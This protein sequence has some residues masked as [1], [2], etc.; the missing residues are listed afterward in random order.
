MPK[1]DRPEGVALPAHLARV[2]WPYCPMCGKKLDRPS[3]SGI[4]QGCALPE[5]DGCGAAFKII[6]VEVEDESE[7]SE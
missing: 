7:S 2:L 5:N 3:K 1:V 6:P 4:L